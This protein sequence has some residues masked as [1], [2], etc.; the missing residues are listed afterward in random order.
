MTCSFTLLDL[1]TQSEAVAAYI[2]G[3][4]AAQTLAWL[5]QYG[6]VTH[7]D[8]PILRDVYTFNS[9][10]GMTTTFRLTDDGTIYIFSDHTIRL[11]DVSS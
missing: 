3:F 2:R 10:T 6:T 1:A 8:H 4:S 7:A 9:S 5:K 11:L